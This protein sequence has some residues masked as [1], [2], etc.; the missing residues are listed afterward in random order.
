MQLGDSG[1]LASYSG[2]VAVSSSLDNISVKTI[3]A[4]WRYCGRSIMAQSHNQQNLSLW[5]AYATGFWYAALNYS[6]SP[7]NVNEVEPTVT[8]SMHIF[9][10]TLTT[11]P[12]P[13]E[14]SCPTADTLGSLV[15]HYQL[16]FAPRLKLI[17]QYIDLEL[18]VFP[19]AGGRSVYLGRESYALQLLTYATVGGTYSSPSEQTP[20]R[21]STLVRS[22]HAYGKRMEPMWQT[23]AALP[24]DSRMNLILYAP[25]LN[26]LTSLAPTVAYLSFM[27]DLLTTDQQTL[28]N[29]LPSLINGLHRIDRLRAALIQTQPTNSRW[30]EDPNTDSLFTV[31]HRVCVRQLL[32][33]VIGGL[34]AFS[35]LRRRNRRALSHE[36]LSRVAVDYAQTKYNHLPLDI[37]LSIQLT[38]LLPPRVAPE[39]KSTPAFFE[40]RLL[41]SRP[42]LTDVFDSTSPTNES[43]LSTGCGACAIT[44]TGNWDP[45]GAYMTIF[46]GPQLDMY[47]G[48]LP[49]ALDLLLLSL[50]LE[51]WTSLL[52]GTSVEDRPS[53][54]P[55]CSA[56][57]I[58]SQRVRSAFRRTVRLSH[59]VAPILNE[60]GGIG[61]INLVSCTP[62]F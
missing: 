36:L 46:C 24:K 44:A 51:R 14:L 32:A 37:P 60:H 29:S 7:T 9:D 10:T 39:N 40:Q 16:T 12:I 6:T 43:V 45:V 54:A 2:Q 33:V 18:D 61:H 3:I 47:P 38:Y 4:S 23:L 53:P 20:L 5:K 58:N 19:G 48:C 34:S 35:A 41:L 30:S 52:A 56:D 25:L 22:S 57:S 49:V 8:E 62:S 28:S 21:P 50:E 13:D 42:S 17:Q 27:F 1:Q 55:A 11:Y 31:R 26:S 15:D 59:F